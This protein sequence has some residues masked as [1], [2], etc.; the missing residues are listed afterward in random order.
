MSDVVWSFFVSLLAGLASGVV[1]IVLVKGSQLV[2][3]LTAT[4]I[5]G[6]TFLTMMA[7]MQWSSR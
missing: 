4:F 6:G 2:R 5:A 3:A 1:A 7:F